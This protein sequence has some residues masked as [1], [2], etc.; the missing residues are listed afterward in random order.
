MKNIGMGSAKRHWGYV[1]Q[2][3]SGK[4]L[5][6]FKDNMEK[7]SMIHTKAGLDNTKFH[8]NELEKLNYP[9]AAW[10]DEDEKFNIGLENF[11]VYVGALKTPSVPKRYFC[12]WLKDL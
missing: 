11:G 1:K 9:C 5:H 4:R 10:G 2:I 3:K 12:F 7:Q 6:I 8:H